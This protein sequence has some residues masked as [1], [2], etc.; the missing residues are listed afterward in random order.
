MILKGLIARELTERF[1]EV[2]H[3]GCGCVGMISGAM[4][5]CGLEIALRYKDFAEE[6]LNH[7]HL[8]HVDFDPHKQGDSIE[9]WKE[10]LQVA[11]EVAL[12]HKQA[13]GPLS[14]ATVEQFIEDHVGKFHKEDD[15]DQT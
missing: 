8:E 7:L 2:Y 10:L 15:G 14:D 12:E 11:L 3:P 5:E 13:D 4:L 6:L 9:A 1:N